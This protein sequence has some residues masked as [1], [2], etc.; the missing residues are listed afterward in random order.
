MGAVTRNPAIELIVLLLT[1]YIAY[2]VAAF[3]LVAALTGMQ[4]LGCIL[5]EVLNRWHSQ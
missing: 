2:A 3:G 1:A 5:G 4:L